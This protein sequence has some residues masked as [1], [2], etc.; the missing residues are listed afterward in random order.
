VSPICPEGVLLPLCLSVFP[1]KARWGSMVDEGCHLYLGHRHLARVADVLVP[2]QARGLVGDECGGTRGKARQLRRLDQII[3]QLPHVV[4]ELREVRLHR[5]HV[6]ARRRRSAAAQDGA[7]RAR[8][9]CCLRRRRLQPVRQVRRLRCERMRELG[10][11]DSL[12][13]IIGGDGQPSQIRTSPK[14]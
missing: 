2:K 8:K 12:G 1:N 4:V 9:P 6:V 10:P 11:S 3:H 7:Q 14:K 13:R 5:H